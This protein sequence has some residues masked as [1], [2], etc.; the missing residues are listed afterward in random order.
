M[1]YL[2]GLNWLNNLGIKKTESMQNSLYVMASL[3]FRYIISSLLFLKGAL[4]SKSIVGIKY[5]GTWFH[6]VATGQGK[7]RE[8]QGQGKVREFCV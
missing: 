8:I 6:R 1:T 5:S 2:F 4:I 7:V 3:G